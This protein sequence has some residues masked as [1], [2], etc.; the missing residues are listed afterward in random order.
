M[1][2]QSPEPNRAEPRSGGLNELL[3]ATLKCL[4]ADGEIKRGGAH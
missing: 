4:T 2:A 3:A 1:R